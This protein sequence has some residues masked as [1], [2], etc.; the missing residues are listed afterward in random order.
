M[1][2]KYWLESSHTRI[3]PV[4][5]TPKSKILK[6]DAARGDRISFQAAAAFDGNADTLSVSAESHPKTDLPVR[7]RRVGHVPVPHHNTETKEEELDCVGHI[8]GYVPDPLFEEDTAIIGAGETAAFWF[9]LRVPEELPVG[10]VTIPV[11]LRM[12][13]DDDTKDVSD[14]LCEIDVHE[15]V[16]N[17]KR[18]LRVTHWFYCDALLD[19]YRLQPFEERFWTILESYMVDIADHGQD[20]LYVPVFT[21]PLDGVKRPTQ[22]LRVKR[23]S[24]NGSGKDGRKYRFDWNDVKRYIDLARKSGIDYFEWTHFFTQWGCKFAIRIYENQGIEEKL[25]WKPETPA[26]SPTYRD[27][28][29]EFLPELKRFIDSE[30]LTD[31]SF[32]HVSDEPHGDEALE[33]YQSAR[34]L[35]K[36]LAPWMKT[37]DA[38]S[39]IVYARKRITDMPVPSIRV[40]KSF[41]DE[42]WPCWTYFCCGPRGNYLNRLMDTPLIKIRM[43]GWLFYRFGVLGFLHWGYNYW[44]KSQTRSLIDP[45]LESSGLKWPG[46]AYGDTFLVYPGEEGPIDSIRWEIFA[47]SLKDYDL[48]QTAGV[49]RNGKLMS[50]FKDFDSFPKDE[51]WWK[52]ARKSLLSGGID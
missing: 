18:N 41:V 16:L 27:F 9:S 17:K 31:V 1:K 15:P 4:R 23:A 46:W 48:L 34:N 40:T 21:P 33:G 11:T 36:S 10:K 29:S 3:F 35:L 14:L 2:V 25:L 28:L 47:E 50:D 24:G 45:Y 8:P 49:D 44:Y 30:N 6:L 22:L 42:G 39:E 5:N 13:S 7:I 20:T 12:K 32:F 37:M 19:W 26:V 43:A 52:K 51:G 38:L